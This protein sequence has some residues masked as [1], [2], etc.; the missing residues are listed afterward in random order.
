MSQAEETSRPERPAGSPLTGEPVF[1]VIGKLR[2]P[3]GLH[4]EMLM[5]VFTDFPE[6][7]KP[8]ATVYVGDELRP[9]RIRSC[10]PYRQNLLIAFDAYHEPETAGVLRNHLVQVLADALPSLEDGEYYHHQILGLRVVSDEGQELGSVA[11]ILETGANDVFLVRPEAGPEILLPN[12]DPV[13]LAIDLARGEM[14]VH[15]L[16]GLMPD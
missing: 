9:L 14:T 1:L 8:N 6:R 5:D 12:I 3:Y 4:G 16:P 11:E 15:L 13:V 10:R 2:R 7:L